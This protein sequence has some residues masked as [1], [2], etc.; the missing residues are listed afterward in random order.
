MPTVG[1]IVYK[2]MGDNSDLKKSI[3]DVS[4]MIG[5]AAAA[6]GKLVGYLT[7]GA[8]TAFSALSK[9]AVSLY[10]DYEQLSGGAELMFGEAYDFIAEKAKTAF[11]DVQMSQNDYLQQVNGFAVGLKTALGGDEMG[12]AELAD[13]IVKAEADIVAATGNTA[14]A[15][16][17][18]FNG[19]MKSN[20]TMLD[21]L[22]LGI[23]PTKEGFAELIDT[24]NE[25]NAA[26]G[27]ATHYVLDN[28]AD[29]Q[30]ALLDYI[31][32][33]GMSG[34]AQAEAAET[35]SGS[36]ASLQA[37]WD[38]LLTSMADPTQD[39][40]ELVQNVVDSL[41]NVSGNLMPVIQNLM[42]QMARAVNELVGQ[43]LPMIP[44][45]I[46][47]MLPEV[48]SGAN[49]LI[50]ALLD[51]LG[52]IG[53]T[54]I[55]IITENIGT[56][57]QTIITSLG[58]NAPAVLA[59]ALDLV[60]VFAEEL[61]SAENIT[62]L[63]NMCIEIIHVL[64]DGL[65]RN[66]PLLVPTVVQAALTIAE[67][68]IDN[69]DTVIDA[70]EKIIIGLAD[71]L[72]EALPRLAEK[73]P[74]ILIKLNSALISAIPEVIEFAVEFCMRLAD[75]LI[76]YDWSSVG[77]QMYDNVNKALTDALHGE[78]GYSDRMAKE[79]EGRINKYSALSEKALTRMISANSRKMQEYNRVIAEA[80]EKGFYEYEA[81]PD[82]MR[83]EYDHS[84]FDS[85]S[86]FL[87]KRSAETEQ[88]AGD[89]VAARDRIKE[90]AAEIDESTSLPFTMRGAE[91]AEQRAKAHFA[92]LEDTT[93]QST[94][95]MSEQ[96][97]E[98]D[99]LFA[100]HQ[101]SEADYWARRKAIL[102]ANRDDSDPEW[103]KLYDKVTDHYEKLAKTEAQ[104]AKAAERER[105]NS[106]KES[107]QNKFRDLETEQITKEYDDQWLVDQE[108]AFIE[109]LDH[110]SEAYKDYSL[111]I[112]KQQKKIDDEAAKEA[113]RAAEEQQKAIEKAYS[114]LKSQYSKIISERDKISGKAFDLSSVFGSEEVTDKRTGAKK[115]NLSVNSLD[116]KIS[117]QRK[118]INQIRQMQA[119]GVSNDLIN[120]LLNCDP[121][122]AVMYAAKLLNS[123]N[124]LKN[125]DN[126]IAELKSLSDETGNTVMKDKF[127][128]LGKDAGELFGE[129]FKA[130]LKENAFAAF[131]EVFSDDYII[132]AQ[133]NVSASSANVGRASAINNTS[134]AAQGTSSA[135]TAQN[136]AQSGADGVYK[137]VDING[138]YVAKVVNSENKKTQI[139][140]GG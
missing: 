48:L 81:M 43:I 128:K 33:Q 37:A 103:W 118:L 2:V 49:E 135:A 68:L 35:L 134:A 115:K 116:K 30:S 130:S 96:L 70:A 29:C 107:V 6:A 140:S 102:E 75:S 78:S 72:I 65:N 93:V 99:A 83:M 63:M 25:W 82:W 21:N 61:L 44:S 11:K 94:K 13:R 120:E 139:Q 127:G 106:I 19:I 111:T 87:E 15:V 10:A 67:T 27:N 56:I 89:L 38:N 58:E 112:L 104:A 119:N 101:V 50:K 126:Q 54:A 28:L 85:I 73:T 18:A 86:E 84:E 7:S 109:T 5:S 77:A 34:Y 36:M 9:Q 60:T 8:A 42:P 14:E 132:N 69:I 57:I 71:G 55:P 16:Q 133:A 125:L 114:G 76:S 121:E 131:E 117:A 46:N 39:L 91:E 40:N 24:V 59:T 41:V 45:T 4:G 26:N 66:L 97:D 105:E 113:E 80:A 51:A 1:E 137:V 47:A 32:I 20:F 108:K 129:S 138:T 110:N 12:A 88:L 124:A 31:E 95:S 3:G 98:L 64:A 53:T 52:E 92:S 74:A 62:M 136:R 90:A 100:V 22:Q 123:P 23:T 17:N 79:E 122:E